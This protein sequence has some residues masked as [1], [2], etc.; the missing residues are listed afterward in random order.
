MN[1][2]SIGSFFLLLLFLFV[3]LERDLCSVVHSANGKV[4]LTVRDMHT[5]THS[6]ADRKPHIKKD[7]FLVSIAIVGKV[8]YSVVCSHVRLSLSDAIWMIYSFCLVRTFI[9][10][11][12]VP[13]G[14]MCSNDSQRFRETDK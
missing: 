6:H 8:V 14:D 1:G 11:V 12:E 4:S 7:E 10:V 9:R 2:S 13:V 3:Y 5:R